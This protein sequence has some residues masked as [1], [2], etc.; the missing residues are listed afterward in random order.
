V[1]ESRDSPNFWSTPYY[2]R[3]GESY[4][5]QIWQ[6]YSDCPCKQKPYKNL[7]ENKAWAYTG[8]AQIFWVPP[9]ISGTDKATNFKFG[10]C[11]HSVRPN[12]S[13]LKFWEKMER[14]RIEG[15]PKFFE[16]PILSQELVKLWTSNFVRTFLVSIGTKVRY[17]FLEK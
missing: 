2:L 9:I 15:L 7:G 13:P 1:G 17:K 4:E 10:S 16:Y 5:R 11:I 12:K 3:N 6:I 14:G 8:T